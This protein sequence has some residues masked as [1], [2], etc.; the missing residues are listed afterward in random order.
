MFRLQVCI[1]SVFNI[2]IDRAARD[3]YETAGL[4]FI[5]IGVSIFFS[6]EH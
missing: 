3:I 4:N 6:F 2:V 5:R 1:L